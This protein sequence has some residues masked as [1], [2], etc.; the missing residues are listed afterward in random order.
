M[1]DHMY[2][3][4]RCSDR[5]GGEGE[6]K[7]AHVPLTAAVAVHVLQIAASSSSAVLPPAFHSFRMHALISLTVKATAGHHYT[8]HMRAQYHQA[9]DNHC[10]DSVACA[11]TNG[12][13]PR[14]H[15]FLYYSVNR[16]SHPF[17]CLSKTCRAAVTRRQL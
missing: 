11:F 6:L 1:R 12:F 10:V 7:C 16:N 15:S 2:S 9:L 14:F 17:V 5:I 13:C 4:E 3:G 8:H